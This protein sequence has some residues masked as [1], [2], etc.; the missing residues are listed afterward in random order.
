MGRRPGPAAIMG[1]KAADPVV[2]AAGPD[3]AQAPVAGAGRAPRGAAW[4]VVGHM[5]RASV[6]R[7]VRQK[8]RA[9]A[10]SVN[11]SLMALTPRGAVPTR[12]DARRS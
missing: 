5:R 6:I 1:V 8:Y 11:G 3:A 12:L 10:G 9:S 7:R 2:F 4:P